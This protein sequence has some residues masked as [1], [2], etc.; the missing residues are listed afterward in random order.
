MFIN[1]DKDGGLRKDTIIPW[2]LPNERIIFNRLT[3]YTSNQS[4]KNVLIMGNKTWKAFEQQ[5]GLF[6]S[7]FHTNFEDRIIIVLSTKE[8]LLHSISDFYI[9]NSFDNLF[10]IIKSRNDIENIWFIGGASIYKQCFKYCSKIFITTVKTSFNCNIKVEGIDLSFFEKDYVDF[11]DFTLSRFIKKVNTNELQYLTLIKK[12]F[13][14]S[15]EYIKNRTNIDT[16]KLFVETCRYDLTDYKIP[17]LTTKRMFWRAI[18]EE[19]LW[20]IKGDTNNTTLTKK[21]INIWSV[22]ADDSPDLGP[23]YGFQWRHY[24]ATYTD[25]YAN[26]SGLGVDQLQNVIQSIKEDPSSRRHIINAW[27]PVDLQKMKLPPCHCFIQFDVDSENKTLKSCLYQRSGDVG[28]G[29]PFNIAS[30]SLLTHIIAELTNLK[31]IEF[32]H[33]IGNVHIYKNHEKQLVKQLYLLPNKC[34]YIK[35]NKKLKNI[36]DITFN[37][38]VLMDYHSYDQLP[39]QINN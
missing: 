36:E 20:F 22:N 28:L 19:L 31:A 14:S 12:I 21:G 8:E 38:I 18:V 33:V 3:L 24:G 6:H 5:S 9:A 2:K 32:V 27:N 23:I 39:M 15:G 17:L 29:I 1:C 4:S 7:Y 34:P 10:D 16:I 26:Y 37:D 11:N 30:Y 13:N 35:F 25:C